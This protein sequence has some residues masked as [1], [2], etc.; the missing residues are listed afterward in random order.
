VDHKNIYL[1]EF[2]N[3]LTKFFSQYNTIR[4]AHDTTKVGKS[5]F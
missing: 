2:W 5:N 3:K 4:G 1:D